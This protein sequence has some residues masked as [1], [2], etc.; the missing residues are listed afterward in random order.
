[1]NDKKATRIWQQ[2]KGTLTPRQIAE[3]MAA[4]QKN[5]LRLLEDA[6]LLLDARRFSS[7]SFMAIIAI[8]EY[9]KLPILDTMV[10]T[11]PDEIKKKWQAYRSHRHKNQRWVLPQFA[12]SGLK[13]IEEFAS[14]TNPDAPH[15]QLLDELKQLCLYTECREG[16]R[17]S[18]PSTFSSEKMAID[19][20]SFAERL[21]SDK[22]V[23]VELLEI[24]AKHLLPAAGAPPEEWKRAMKAMFDEARS[25]GLLDLSESTVQTLLYGKMDLRGAGK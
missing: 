23:P 21:I 8:E 9:G 25:A 13:S 20:I 15:T 14:A 17:W 2:F 24:E 18:E 11:P 7:A 6:R 1:M 10:Y 3:G 4:A 12:D 19:L 16:V 5:A 22:P